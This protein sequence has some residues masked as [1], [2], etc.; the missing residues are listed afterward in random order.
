MRG[1]RRT[2]KSDRSKAALTLVVFRRAWILGEG[3]ASSIDQ[4]E[5][6]IQLDLA[7][8]ARDGPMMK[9]GFLGYGFYCSYMG[10]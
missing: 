2:A 3:G 10:S 7:R 4:A 6:L 5:L 9:S 8:D 1:S